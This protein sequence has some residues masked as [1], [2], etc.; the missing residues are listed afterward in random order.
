MKPDWKDHWDEDDAELEQA[1]GDVSA[2]YHTGREPAPRVPR[3]LDRRVRE[4][5]RYHLGIELDEVAANHWIFGHGPRLSLAASL[6]F[7]IGVY[8]VVS[9]EQEKQ[10]DGLIDSAAP[11]EM[12]PAPVPRLERAVQRSADLESR[13]AERAARSQSVR[14]A[15]ESQALMAPGQAAPD[16]PGV[17]P[18]I[19]TACRKTSPGA[20]IEFRFV[21]DADGEPASPEVVDSCKPVDRPGERD[22]Q[23]LADGFTADEV[24]AA[25][26]AL[27]LRRFAP[28]SEQQVRIELNDED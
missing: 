5:A 6:M 2:E 25:E 12:A 11:E 10:I 26:E 20:W 22:S 8:F 23:C 18:V 3:S 9:L 27:A 19:V 13:R 15:A 21:T 28:L 17:V 7:G 16:S 4:Q 1:F 14:A 24:S